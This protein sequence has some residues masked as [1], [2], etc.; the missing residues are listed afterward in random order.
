MAWGVVS[1]TAV[2]LLAMPSTSAQT[3]PNLA[4]S[5]GTNHTVGLSWPYANSGFALQQTATLPS[6][7]WLTATL[8]PTF[9]S[10]AA[11]FSV[12]AP[13][14]NSAGFFR[15]A[16]PADLRGI[17]VYS[18]DVT[19]ISTD[20]AQM[21]SNSLDVSGVDGLVLV[22]GWNSLEPT[23]GQFAWTTLDPWITEAASQG[24]KIDLAIPAGVD[25]PGWLFQPATDGGA[26]A[27]PLVF[28]I[29]PHQGATSN[30][31]SETIAAPWDPAFLNS[32]NAM[33]T[34]LA[35]HL[36][37]A[38]TYSNVTLLRLTGINR[39]TD[40]L[41][42]PAETSQDTGLSCVSN[43]PEIWQAAGY[44]PDLLLYGWSNI[45][46]SFQASF[47]DKSFSVAIIPTNAFPSINNNGQITNNLPDPNQPL[48]AFAAQKL[49]GRLVVQ[50]NF[51]M[52]SNPADPSVIQ[53]ARQ[54]GT[55]VAY[56]SN[57]YYGSTGGGAACGGTITNP[58]LCT[59]AT[60]LNELDEGIYPLTSTNALRAQYIEA[61]PT[62][63]IVFTNAIWQAHE[64][65]FAPP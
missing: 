26:G 47:P 17:F 23:N 61:F 7:N 49:V 51:L 30:C 24:K 46:D 1:G 34:N 55:L 54:Y 48:L 44:T 50:Y 28:T 15:L 22:I 58:V 31:I 21:V 52:T 53:S 37:S 4:I 57:N 11:V 62:N 2:W 56:Q 12:S 36:Q 45:V 18:S 16:L 64:E 19:G 40:E 29:S 9:A 27:S 13:A 39:T 59:D 8:S 42:L 35:S 63:A 60:Y 33:L 32:W 10:N 14:T 43:A 25:T 38:G 6:S 3:L 65:L 20:Y 41:R 5:P